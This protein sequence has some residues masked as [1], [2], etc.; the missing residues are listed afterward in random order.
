MNENQ[1]QKK[2]KKKTEYEKKCTW[3]G[4]GHHPYDLVVL[5]ECFL[6]SL[7]INY[8]TYK[9]A[10]TIPTPHRGFMRIK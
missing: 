1:S 5:T 4:L 6:I 2:K 8:A 7:N 9:T 3:V 10:V